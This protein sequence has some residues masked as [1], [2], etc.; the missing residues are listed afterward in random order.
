MMDLIWRCFGDFRD[1]LLLEYEKRI[2][3]NLKI[4][5]DENVIDLADFIETDFRPTGFTR[6]NISKVIISEFN[7]WLETV[8]VPDYSTNKVFH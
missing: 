3:N 7:A 1:K 5:Y 8:G 6:K 4:S 2:Y